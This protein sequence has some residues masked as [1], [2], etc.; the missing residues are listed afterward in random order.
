[1]VVNKL[2]NTGL[3]VF[4]QVVENQG[5]ASLTHKTRYPQD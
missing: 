4:S 3:G 5:V 2:G 1:L